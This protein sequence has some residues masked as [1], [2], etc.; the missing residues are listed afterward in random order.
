MSSMPPVTMSPGRA[1]L[2]ASECPLTWRQAQLLAYEA[3]AERP[4]WEFGH[5]LLWGDFAEVGEWLWEY[6]IDRAGSEAENQGED[7]CLLDALGRRT[8]HG[9]FT[10]AA[11][12]A[13]AAAPR[14]PK[15]W[16]AG[17]WCRSSLAP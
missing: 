14:P 8:A 1:R 17:D 2:I 6:W 16:S 10:C 11:T 7:A 9:H 13:S 3:S 4:A 5:W 15:E 12:T